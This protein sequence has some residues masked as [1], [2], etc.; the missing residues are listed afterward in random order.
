MR[1]WIAGAMTVLGTLLVLSG[2]VTIIMRTW[3]TPARAGEPVTVAEE[4][5]RG[6]KSLLRFSA[7]DRLIGWGIVLLILA[8]VAAGAISFNLGAAAPAK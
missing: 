5:D 7:P 8:A 1:N 6:L 3:F 4:Q 2:A